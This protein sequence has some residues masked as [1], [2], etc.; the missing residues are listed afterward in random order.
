MFDLRD[1]F[2]GSLLNADPFAP[3]LVASKPKVS[4]LVVKRKIGRILT[5]S[6]TEMIADQANHLYL[7]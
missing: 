2:L 4:Q 6:H 5:F 3:E 7:A 1:R